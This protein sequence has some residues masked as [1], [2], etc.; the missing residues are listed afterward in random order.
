MLTG[1]SQSARVGA[2]C[3]LFTLFAVLSGFGAQDHV[4]SP[5]ELQKA[6]V[7]ETHTREHNAEVVSKF[8]SSPRAK[9]A[10]ESAHLKPAQV[11]TAIA[12]MSDDEVAQLATR[13]EKSQTDF[14][15][16]NMSNRDLIWLILAVVV[17][18]LVIIAVR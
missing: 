15:A 3:I 2:A 5:A 12:K 11:K 17:L 6:A 1:K 7:A 16:G 14:A 18:I 13:V 4:V 9:Q 10:L 8:M